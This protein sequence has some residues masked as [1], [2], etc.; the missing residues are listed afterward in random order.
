MEK[1]KKI[2]KSDQKKKSA[3]S[4][5]CRGRLVYDAAQR[6]SQQISFPPSMQ[7]QWQKAQCEKKHKIKVCRHQ[8][9]PGWETRTR[10]KD[11]ES[12]AGSWVSPGRKHKSTR[13]FLLLFRQ[14]NKGIGPKVPSVSLPV[15]TVLPKQFLF[16]ALCLQPPLKKI[17]T[18]HWTF[19]QISQRGQCRRLAVGSLAKLEGRCLEAVQLLLMLPDGHCQHHSSQCEWV[20]EWEI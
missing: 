2:M 17:M 10:R 5:V 13:F 1:E 15:P 9:F 14:I 6:L 7:H 19:K 4:S 16:L 12:R 11:E 20:S 8:F 3:V 18:F